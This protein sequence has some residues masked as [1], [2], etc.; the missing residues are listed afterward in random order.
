MSIKSQGKEG[1]AKNI[2]LWKFF[3]RV[4][5]GIIIFDVTIQ[6]VSSSSSSSRSFSWLLLALE[7]CIFR[8]RIPKNHYRCFQLILGDETPL[9]VR[10]PL[11]PPFIL[12]H[13]IVLCTI[14][15]SCTKM[16]GISCGCRRSRLVCNIACEN[17]ETIE[18]SNRIVVRQDDDDGR[19]EWW[20]TMRMIKM[21]TM[22]AIKTS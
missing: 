2:Q 18:C 22:T 19:D 21:T 11:W 14:F 12:L 20:F 10:S 13:K 15:C 9:I 16:C 6:I 17:Y 8:N 4:E 3:Y 7:A 5:I 1:R